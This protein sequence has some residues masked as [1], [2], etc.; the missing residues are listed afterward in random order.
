MAKR[1]KAKVEETEKEIVDIQKSKVETDIKPENKK[2]D[3]EEVE[4]P[5]QKKFKNVPLKN[6]KEVDVIKMSIPN[7]T[8]IFGNFLNKNE[9]II[10]SK[11]NGK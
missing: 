8:D 3:I 11:T 1:T 7:P 5:K 2:S 9:V 6:Y 10:G 4:K